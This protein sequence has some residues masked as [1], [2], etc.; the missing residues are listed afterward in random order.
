MEEN[1]GGGENRRGVRRGGEGTTRAAQQAD[2]ICW[3]TNKQGVIGVQVLCGGRRGGGEK[4]EEVVN[5]TSM[6]RRKLGDL[7]GN[8]RRTDHGLWLF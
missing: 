2:V 7:I 4:R 6:T 3:H 1:E 8:G 5:F